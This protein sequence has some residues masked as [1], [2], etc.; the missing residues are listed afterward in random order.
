LKCPQCGEEHRLLDPLFK[1]PDFV[2]GL[3]ADEQTK[4]VLQTDDV[5]SVEPAGDEARRHFVRCTLPFDLTDVGGTTQWGLWAEIAEKDATRM[6]ELWS[7]PEQQKE[8]PFRGVVA[9]H[10][11]GY[12]ETLGLPV[13]VR[14]TGPATRPELAF[15]VHVQ[16][17]L[18]AEYRSGVTAH[19]V[20]EWLRAMGYKA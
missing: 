13:E 4:R 3:P 17:P 5:C 7:D 18:A 19:R 12:P 15:P 14:L 11:P 16:H 9:N 8:P 10:L 6:F 2:F 1:R 20:I